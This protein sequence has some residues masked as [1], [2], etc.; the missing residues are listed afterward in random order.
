MFEHIQTRK[1]MVVSNKYVTKKKAK[2]L[3]FSFLQKNKAHNQIFEKSKKRSF[4][5]FLGFGHY[6][7]EW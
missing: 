4:L 2:L 6:L 3:D 7:R 1:L 5:R